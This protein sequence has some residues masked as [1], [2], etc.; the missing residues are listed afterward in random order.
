MVKKSSDEPD[1]KALERL[2]E[3][4]QKRAPV[5]EKGTENDKKA[6]DKKGKEKEKGNEPDR[7]PDS[8]TD[9]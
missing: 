6:K 3:F 2:R 1:D 5:P 4:E 8:A 7:K 9:K